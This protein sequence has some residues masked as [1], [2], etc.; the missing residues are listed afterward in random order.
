MVA[1]VGPGG[2]CSIC[3]SRGSVH[4]AAEV[5][6]AEC[7]T[8]VMLLNVYHIDHDLYTAS[9]K[10]RAHPKPGLPCCVLRSRGRYVM[11]LNEEITHHA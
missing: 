2:S 5:S 9:R 6:C 3:G 10:T 11:L 8:Y 1:C 4:T 7:G